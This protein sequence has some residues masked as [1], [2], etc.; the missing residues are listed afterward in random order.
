MQCSA[1]FSSTEHERL[2]KKAPFRERR[3]REHQKRQGVFFDAGHLTATVPAWPTTL[4][5]LTIQ[6]P[7]YNANTTSCEVL[8]SAATPF[9][10]STPT[11]VKP[12]RT[13]L[14]REWAGAAQ[15][16]RTH[17]VKVSPFPTPAR[18]SSVRD[19]CHAWVVYSSLDS[20]ARREKQ[21]QSPW[22]SRGSRHSASVVCASA[23]P[24]HISGECLRQ[25]CF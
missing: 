14:F 4:G 9:V 20:A 7:Q 3:G 13:D 11:I 24:N 5:A 22:G 12:P 8:R 10:C 6:Y 25:L 19:T 17:H 21:Q 23:A 16:D 2:A 18:R 15:D 1:P